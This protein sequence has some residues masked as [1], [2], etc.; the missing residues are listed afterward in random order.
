MDGPED[1]PKE[2]CPWTGQRKNRKRHP[3][4]SV[5]GCRRIDVSK[6]NLTM[7]E[8]EKAFTLA[9]FGS[10]S[11]L[12][13]HNLI[14][15]GRS[16]NPR[17]RHSL[18]VALAF[19]C[20]ALLV[21]TGIVQV[22]HIHPDNQAVEQSDAHFARRCSR[23]RSTTDLQSLP[24]I[25]SVVAAVATVLL[26]IRPRHFSIFSPPPGLRL[27]RLL[28]HKATSNAANTQ[29]LWRPLCQGVTVI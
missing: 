20:C 29:D 11:C 19:F 7:A 26:L 6:V 28:S 3:P 23:S 10:A 15:P 4:A 13:G 21:Y 8:G 22:G 27:W 9:N 2:V 5:N 25:V 24:H 17:A 18:W 14:M 1:S 16:L 12:A